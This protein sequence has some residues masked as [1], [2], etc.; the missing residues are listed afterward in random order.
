M[1]HEQ[2]NNELADLHAKCEEYLAGWKR[3]QADYQNLERE[4]EGQ[5]GKL[6]IMATSNLALGLLPI[7]DHYELAVKH[8][9]EGKSK[10]EWVQGFIH[11]KKLFDGFLENNSIKKIKTVG[12]QFDPNWHEAVSVQESDKKEDE[13]IDEVQAGYLLNN[14]VLR[15]AKVV[16]AKKK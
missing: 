4:H 16:V 6:M 15:H 2:K 11:I 13:I 3:A 12:E 8:I 7:I 14:Q 9:P 1:K 10:D 5:M